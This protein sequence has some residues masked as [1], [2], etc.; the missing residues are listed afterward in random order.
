MKE[1]TADILVALGRT[2][3]FGLAVIGSLAATKA[4]YYST[5]VRN[6]KTVGGEMVRVRERDPIGNI[7]FFSRSVVEN[8]KKCTQIFYGMSPTGE[9][10]RKNETLKPLGVICEPN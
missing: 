4:V 5:S 9:A 1:E 7:P 3:I 8:G 10:T 2:F 6:M